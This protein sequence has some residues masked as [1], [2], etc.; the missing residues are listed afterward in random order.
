[1]VISKQAELNQLLL[2]CI[3]KH[4]LSLKNIVSNIEMANFSYIERLQDIVSD[5]LIEKGFDIDDKPTKYGLQ[6]EELIDYLGNFYSN[7]S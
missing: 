2:K 5:E 1:M 3:E 7:D 4:D 6:L